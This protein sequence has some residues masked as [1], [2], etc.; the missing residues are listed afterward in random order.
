VRS[1][2]SP[3]SRSSAGPVRPTFFPSPSALRRWLQTHHRTAAELWVG[4]HKR[5]TARPSITWPQLVDQVLCFGWIDGVRKRLDEDRYVIRITPRKPGSSWSAVNLRRVQQLTKLGLMT[6]TGLTAFR[7]RDRRKTGYSYEERPQRLTGPYARAL[8]ANAKAYEF[9][10]A[11]A[12]WYQRTVSFWVLSAKREETRHKRL[13]GLIEASAAG[14]RVGILER[15]T[16]A[17]R[18]ATPP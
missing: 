2:S 9:F 4:F 15:P 5:H 3:R 7:N 17:T 13:A 11:Q 16:P 12:P 1:R 10:R 8:R 14:R 18:R 6:A